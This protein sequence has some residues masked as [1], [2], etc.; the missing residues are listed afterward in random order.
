M[1]GSLVY[2]HISN[3]ITKGKFDT[4]TK[5]CIMLGYCPNGYQLWSLEDRKVVSG[6]DIIFDESKT[7]HSQGLMN[8]DLGSDGEDESE[9][10]N[11][12]E[13]GNQERSQKEEEDGQNNRK[14]KRKITRPKYLEDYTVLALHVESFIE[15]VPQ[16]FEDIY[17]RPDQK[18]WMEALMEDAAA[19]GIGC[20]VVGVVQFVIG[21]S[22]IAVLNFVAQ[23]Q[24]GRVRKLFLQAV[25]HQ[26]MAWYDT[27]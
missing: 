11:E 3:E 23:K 10:G 2:L 15:D 26:D 21:A 20:S 5:K 16:C 7:V 17:S 18:Q 25:L 1:F 14:D 6:R 13:K 27:T 8:S 12:E 19:F 22:S 4:R 24:I 9:S